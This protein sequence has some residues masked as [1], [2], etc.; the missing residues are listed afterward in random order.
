MELSDKILEDPKVI[1]FF[2]ENILLRAG[3][4]E[5]AFEKEGWNYYKT[6][7]FSFKDY[8]SKKMSILGHVEGSKD[9]RIN[10]FLENKSSRNIVALS[11]FSHYIEYNLRKNAHFEDLL[12]ISWHPHNKKINLQNFGQFT[13]I[14]SDILMDNEERYS[15]GVY[16]FRHEDL[17][18]TPT[19]YMDDTM[20]WKKYLS[21]LFF[22]IFTYG[23]FQSK[24]HKVDKNSLVEKTIDFFKQYKE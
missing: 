12:R 21:Q 17:N 16:Y 9:E 1:K 14:N 15:K 3:K 4:V 18:K 6:I 23:D 20:E 5:C 24:N 10:S 11:K 8:P 13:K 7:V 2:A 22:S 19:I